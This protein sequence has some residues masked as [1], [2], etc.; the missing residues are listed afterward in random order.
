MKNITTWIER[1]N[2]QL[3]PGYKNYRWN[4]SWVY[5]RVGGIG[6][7][8]YMLSSEAKLDDRGMSSTRS[9]GSMSFC[10]VQSSP[11]NHILRDC[12]GVWLVRYM[13]EVR[14]MID[15]NY[16]LCVPR[17][18]LTHNEKPRFVY[19]T[20]LLN[21]WRGQWQQSENVCKYYVI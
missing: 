3:I 11:S 6:V 4:T 19:L 2:W 1:K 20:K 5:C 16:L 12:L 10:K 21:H 7:L 18:T 13:L 17:N 15:S 9:Q 8:L 14:F